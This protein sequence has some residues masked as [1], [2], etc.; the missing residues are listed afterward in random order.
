MLALRVISNRLGRPL[1][2]IV[3]AYAVAAQ[4][5]L[6][7]FGGFALAAPADTGAPAFELCLHDGQAAPEPSGGAPS[8]PSCAHCIFCFAGSHH[9]AAAA[10]PALF[11]RIDGEFVDVPS[12][13]DQHAL[14]RPSDYAIASPRGPPARA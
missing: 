1:L 5:L 12:V 9:A 3:V 13:S 4:S 11:H 6:V 7:A 8:H 10:P 14:P 2:G